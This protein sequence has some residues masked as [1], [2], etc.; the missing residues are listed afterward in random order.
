MKNVL[1]AALI[2]LFAAAVAAQ[3]DTHVAA[4]GVGHAQLVEL[5][6]PPA[7]LPPRQLIGPGYDIQFG[8]WDGVCEAG[9][10]A[11]DATKDAA[12]R[13]VAV[14]KDI[15][16][17]AT[18]SL[19]AAAQALRA[20]WEALRAEAGRF[21]EDPTGWTEQ[22]LEGAVKA[23]RELAASIDTLVDSVKAEFEEFR[24]NPEAWLAAKHDTLKA[25][26]YGKLDDV[27]AFLREVGS[28]LTE[29]GGSYSEGFVDT[30]KKDAVNI[31]AGLIAGAAELGSLG[32]LD[33]SR[34]LEAGAVADTASVEYRVADICGSILCGVAITNA[35]A[36][37]ASGKVGSLLT[38]RFFT[39]GRF[40]KV[41]ESLLRALDKLHSRRLDRS[42]ELELDPAEGRA[43]LRMALGGEVGTQAHHVIPLQLRTHEILR[44]AARGGFDI[45]GEGN[46]ISL[47]SAIHR[48]SHPK[49][50][51]RVQDALDQ[52]LQ[53]VDGLTDREVADWL[54]TY[55]AELKKELAERTT[56]LD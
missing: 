37:L 10:D 21:C 41:R 38:N 23:I 20:A 16:D 35:T 51:K 36:G 7:E 54:G 48:G 9:S 25:W 47:P 14:A 5:A 1:I 31:S 11:W 40:A 56:R 15:K 24:E 29:R 27:V 45:N 43:K 18:E 32:L 50:T 26:F 55:T 46:G 2:C 12:E 53:S 39:I 22:Q 6:G 8:F 28:Y 34:A 30:A 13:G 42:S 49:Y 19:D 3:P 52:K 17:Q 44:R 33:F 4:G